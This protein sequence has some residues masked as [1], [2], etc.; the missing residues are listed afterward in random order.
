MAQA[1]G[2][3]K[4]IER[5]G[6]SLPMDEAQATVLIDLGGRAELIWDVKFTSEKIGDVNSQMFS[7][8]FKSFAEN[9]RCNLHIKASGENDHH[10][11]EGVFKAFARALKCAIRKDQYG[12]GIAS[13]KG[14][15]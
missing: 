5:Y 6:F 7:H 9:A 1:I 2:E 4:G 8:F 14:S 10:I 13:S 12:Y 15:I 11:I 3:K